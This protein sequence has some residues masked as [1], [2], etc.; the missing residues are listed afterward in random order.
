VHSSEPDFVFG[1][2]RGAACPIYV[3]KL[4]RDVSARQ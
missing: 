1:Y 2:L 4:T 3:E